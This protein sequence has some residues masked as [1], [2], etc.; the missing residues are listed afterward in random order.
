MATPLE[1][2]TRF[3]DEINRVRQE[4]GNT[5]YPDDEFW[6][7]GHADSGYTLLPS[8]F[9]NKATNTASERRKLW[10]LESDLY[11]EF[12]ARA[13]E[14]HNLPA[15][16]WDYLFAMQHHGTPTRLLDWTEVLGVA[17][18]F[19]LVDIID[20]Y[21]KNKKIPKQ[22]SPCVWVLNPNALNRQSGWS[23]GALLNPR[24]LGW[25]AGEE[26]YYSYEELLLEDGIGWNGPVAIYPLQKTPRM[27]AQ[28]GWFTMHGEKYRPLEDLSASR[29][30]LRRVPIPVDAI[31]SALEF[32][33]FA[34]IGH[35]SLFP[36]L[37]NLSKQ[38]RSKFGI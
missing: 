25:D 11:W 24:N 16:D 37:V 4:I 8:L 3:L 2:W 9:R 29:K 28:H 18:Y 26:V 15:V 23:D 33:A 17:V 36:D 14:L 10:S 34:G 13:R 19:A 35:Y 27:H 21:A 6:Y 7:R 31:P 22:Y 32:L 30:F 38:L 20:N 12:S 5:A 1:S